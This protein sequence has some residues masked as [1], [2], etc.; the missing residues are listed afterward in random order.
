GNVTG[1]AAGTTTIEVGYEGLSK[2]VSVTVTG[3]EEPGEPSL[4]ITPTSLSLK[5]GASGQ[6][7][8]TYKDAEGNE[9]TVTDA[10]Y[11][12]QNPQ[13]ATVMAN[14]VVTALKAGTTAIDVT[15][16]GLTEHV[17]VTVTAANPP[18]NGGGSGG[19]GSSSGGST[20]TT[21]PTPPSP[22]VPPKNAVA[23]KA[24]ETTVVKLPNGFTLTIPEG[25]ITSPEAAFVQVTPATE[26]ETKKL[27]EGLKLAAGIQP[28]G[29][30]YNINILTK[31]G[32]PL[33]NITLSKPA[34]AAIPLTALNPGAINGEKISF[35][36]LGDKGQLAQF[37]GRV[38]DGKVVAN[39]YGFS[40][41]MYLAKNITFTDV[42]AAN[43]PWA[44][45]EIEVL[46]SK[47][48]V[49]GASDGSFHP[50]TQVTRAEFV[51]ML[52]RALELK[53]DQNAAGA[54]TFSDVPAGSWYE[55]AVKTATSK[56]IISGYADG[57]FA[58]DRPITRA[59]MAVVVSKALDV[60]GQSEGA[61]GDLAGFA[62]QD[63]I[64]GWA[65]E[66]VSKVTGLGIM[67]GK[68]GGRFESGLPT[69]RAEAAVVVYRIF[70]D[71]KN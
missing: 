3:S 11:L 7:T 18:S 71:F 21:T 68:A 15:Y 6:L 32:K 41:Y 1:K 62:D 70:K 31:D 65:S 35:Y 53:P 47:D 46:A 5:E 20:S 9:S 59:E 29:I 30:Y 45:N 66:A 4:K 10:V 37:F 33:E 64:P 42:T 57:V 54:V 58:P 8:V 39:L 44:V 12:S 19:G 24:G 17:A 49:A 26:D 13:I 52:V 16:Q 61:S 34:E 38:A 43:Y 50:E 23:I 51:S 40:R 25:A 22:P 14:G 67:K 69:T 36:K 60:L 28:F 55:D 63:R 56:G 48:I 2:T 27:L